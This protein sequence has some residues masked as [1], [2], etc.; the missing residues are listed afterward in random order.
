MT[1]AQL[2]ITILSSSAIGAIVTAI[3]NRRKNEVDTEDKINQ[4]ALRW[5]EKQDRYIEKQDKRMEKQDVKITSLVQCLEAVNKKYTEMKSKYE[6]VKEENKHLKTQ[7]KELSD[8]LDR[9]KTSQIVPTEAKN[10]NLR[11]LG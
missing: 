10:S 3:I 6:E 8:Q 9:Y 7:V 5:T 2:L 4:M 11:G 1:Y